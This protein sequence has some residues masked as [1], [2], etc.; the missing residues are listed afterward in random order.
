MPYRL[1]IDY[2]IVVVFC[3]ELDLEFSRAD[4]EF[5]GLPVIF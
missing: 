5:A 1:P 3:C 2:L 4:I